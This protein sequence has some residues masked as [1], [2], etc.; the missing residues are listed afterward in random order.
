M[1]V[2]KVHISWRLIKSILLT[3]CVALPLTSVAQVAGN[4]NRAVIEIISIE[5]RDPLFIKEQLAPA[6]DVRGSIGLVDDKLIIASTAGNLEQLR[7]IINKSDVPARRLVVS[8]DFDHGSV[9]STASAS[10][11][12]S[13][14]ALEGDAVSFTAEMS[15]TTSAAAQIN[16]SSTVLGDSV[17]ADVEIFNVPGFSGIYP[18]TLELGQWYVINPVIEP[19]QNNEPVTDLEIANAELSS[20]S[21]AITAPAP[22]PAGTPVAVRVDVLP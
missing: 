4:E 8:V 11:Q 16:I 1:L 7:E 21:P 10:A 15:D 20:A 17:A 2:V 13:A 3:F 14:Q 6:L 18:L 9:R 19:E 12:Q 22:M 5:H